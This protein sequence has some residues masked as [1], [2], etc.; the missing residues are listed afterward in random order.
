MAG[1][2]G[3]ISGHN[4]KLY[5]VASVIDTPNTTNVAAAAN[6]SNEIIDLADL[7]DLNKS[8]NIIELNIYGQDAKGKLVGQADYGTFDFGVH[9][10][11]DDSVHQA[12]RDDNGDAE[13]TFI[14]EIGLGANATYAVFDGYV[15]DVSTSTPIDDSVQMSVSVA[16]DGAPVW[17]DAA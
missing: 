16:V 17:I 8:R 13:H 5:Y 6:S 11:L 9:L 1:I 3:K 15:A 4:T 12:I 14:L 2:T 7:G 10:N